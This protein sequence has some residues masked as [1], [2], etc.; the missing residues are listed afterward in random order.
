MKYICNPSSRKF[1]SSPGI[2]AAN[3]CHLLLLFLFVRIS[4]FL[5]LQS[6]SKK[7]TSTVSEKNHIIP[8][9]DKVDKVPGVVVEDGLEVLDELLDN[10]LHHHPVVVTALHTDHHLGGNEFLIKK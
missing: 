6:K 9:C 7:F 8:T 10:R 1:V 5:Y 2:Q 4:D 3:M